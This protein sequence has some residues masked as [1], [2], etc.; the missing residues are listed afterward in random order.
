MRNLARNALIPLAF[1]AVCGITDLRAQLSPAEIMPTGALVYVEA[2]DLKSMLEGWLSSPEKKRWQESRHYQRFQNSRLFLKLT[3]RAEQFAVSAGFPI[4]TEQL[5]PFAGRQSALGIY[6]P[7]EQEFL[8]LTEL[9]AAE[10]QILQLFRN[11][12]RFE[13]RAQDGFT[14]YRN[15]QGGRMVCFAEIDPYL[16]VST[17]EDLIRSALSLRKSPASRTSL[18]RTREW[19][20][21]MSSQESSDLR[22]FL[23]MG[24]LSEHPAFRREWLFGNA[25]ELQPFQSIRNEIFFSSAQVREKRLLV[26]KEKL[27]AVS[28]SLPLELLERYSPNHQTYLLGYAA[29][30]LEPLATRMEQLLWNPVPLEHPGPPRPAAPLGYQELMEAYRRSPFEKS[31]DEPESLTEPSEGKSGTRPARPKLVQILASLGLQAVLE[32]GSVL[33]PEDSPFHFTSYA[34]VLYA[35]GSANL[36][37]EPLR[38]WIQDEFARLYTVS[39]YPGTW[40]RKVLAQVSYDTLETDAGLMP[41]SVARI[42]NALVVAN[43]ED[44]LRKILLTFQAGMPP[45][46][47]TTREPPALSLFARLEFREARDSFLRWQKALDYLQKQNAEEYSEPLFFSEDL[48]GLLQSLVRLQRVTLQRQTATDGV[49]EEIV[50]DSLPRP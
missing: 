13:V 5:I 45:R 19:Q 14:Y 10:R 7:A 17:Q 36:S 26:R 32:T 41:I 18:A 16:A 34:F 6:N 44:S 15:N 35:P 42:G 4:L 43:S 12:S 28:G 20:E 47:F 30:E 1:C 8:F 33:S 2:R 24:S 46:F 9:S 23:A 48:G 25:K 38:G 40:R 3:S 29:P 22:I 11:K 21:T 49:R 50:Y 37:S 39:G 31:I 27:A